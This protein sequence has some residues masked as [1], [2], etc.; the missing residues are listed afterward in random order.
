MFSTIRTQIIGLIA[1]FVLIVA[2]LSFASFA[3]SSRL[4]SALHASEDAAAHIRNHTLSDMFH[5]G[6]KGDVLLAL[7]VA[8]SQD[9]AKMEE[10]IKD[11]KKISAD[12]RTHF[13]KN[14]DVPALAV[15][16][17]A[18][19]PEVE[20]YV[21]MAVDIASSAAQDLPAA[22]AKLPEFLELFEVLTVKLD[23]LGDKIEEELAQANKEAV[24]ATASARMMQFAAIA[25]SLLI[26]VVVANR[27]YGRIVTKLH[28]LQDVIRQ[29]NEG[30]Y[31][32]R[33]QFA[34]QDELDNTGQALDKMLDE[35]VAFLGN[36]EKENEILNNNVIQLLQA[37]LQ[38]SNRDLTVRADVTE[39]VIGTVAAA[40]NQL[41][42]ETGRTLADVQMVA[43]QVRSASSSVQDQ[44]ESVQTRAV[45]EQRA[46]G[47]MAQNLTQAT[48]QLNQV[49][50]LSEESNQAAEKTA[51][52]TEAA[53]RAVTGA[54]SGMDQLRYSISEME[55]R[56]K[57][58]GERSQEISTA[59]GLINTISE[60]T[61]VLALNASMQAAT[62]GEAGRGFAVVAEEVQRLSDSSRQA[63]GQIAQLVTNIQAETNETLQTVNQLISS[64]VAQSEQAQRAGQEMTLTQQTTTQL[65]GLVKQI[66][67]F[68]Q[69]Q[70]A[71]ARNLQASVTEINLGST[72]TV[73]A[74][75]EQTKVTRQLVEQ[76]DRL[77]QTVGLFKVS[78][79]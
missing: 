44:A 19:R 3:A 41:T 48:E 66:A 23:K 71:L 33:T 58:L 52:A 35:R 10:A 30:A 63:T 4:E 17:A 79:A 68:S 31:S 15:D 18:L 57:R 6:T 77:T 56:F 53:L 29:V 22:E 64:V 1:L 20:K 73:S 38:I 50:A 74:I 37:V 9:A 12:L 43:L 59:V 26:L 39:D 55:K 75:T 21:A 25:L 5:D 36:A 28:T 49:A 40:I 2:G 65:V 72:Q 54:V 32:A 45:N 14:K 13:L 69:A 60:R 62:A 34:G 11:V 78:A 47:E 46:L 61:H 67:R 16:I 27:F 42:D 70:A 51:A 8:Q 24:D 76:A 7:R